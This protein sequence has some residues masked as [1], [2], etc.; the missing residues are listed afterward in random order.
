MLI[1]RRVGGGARSGNRNMAIGQD[2]CG[3]ALVFWLIDD[4]DASDMNLPHEPRGRFHRGV[5]FRANYFAIGD[6]TDWHDHL[7]RAK[8]DAH[9]V[10]TAYGGSLTQIKHRATAPMGVSINW[11]LATGVATK[12]S[13]TTD[14]A[15][16]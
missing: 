3:N 1:S 10:L 4:N 16:P 8:S 5:A 14:A 15:L 13:R 9:I 11:H 7:H 12:P 6:I 2:P